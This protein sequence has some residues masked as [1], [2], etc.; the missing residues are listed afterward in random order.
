MVSTWTHAAGKHPRTG[1]KARGPARMS[2]LVIPFL[3]NNPPRW[4]ETVK[5]VKHLVEVYAKDA[6]KHER[7]GEWIER[8][9]GQSQLAIRLAGIA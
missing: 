3:P 4:P 1:L 9:A 8:I 5:A 6:K 7:M 2:K